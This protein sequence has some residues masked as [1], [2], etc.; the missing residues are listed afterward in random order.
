MLVAKADG[1][2]LLGLGSY[3]LN[4][5]EGRAGNNEGYFLFVFAVY[6]LAA[7]SKTETVNADYGEHAVLYFKEGTGVDRSCLVGAYGEEGLADELLENAFLYLYL[8]ESVNG[9]KIGVIVGRGTHNVEAAHAAA[10]LYHESVVGI[11]AYGIVGHLADYIAEE[12]GVE[13]Y[14]AGL[15]NYGVQSGA[16]TGFEIIAGDDGFHASC[17]DEKSLQSRD[18]ALHG[19]GAGSYAYSVCKSGFFAGKFHIGSFLS[20]LRF[21]TSGRTKKRISATF[22][23]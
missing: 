15:G 21:S 8:F 19:Y 6:S 12:L 2:L 13:D 23:A 10:K 20:F 1:G 11:E 22:A 18:G 14:A 16:D 4:F 17:L 7:Q 9:G 3:F 5:G